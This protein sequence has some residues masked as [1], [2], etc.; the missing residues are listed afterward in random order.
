MIQV[1]SEIEQ[2]IKEYQIDRK[3]F[4]E[5]SKQSYSQIQEKIESTFVDKSKHWNAD[6]HWANMGNYNPKLKCVSVPL[7]KWDD[8][9]A[10]LPSIIPSPNDAVYVLFESNKDYQPKYW[11]YE[12]FIDEL[13]SILC[14]INGPD[15]F[16]IVSKKFNWLISIN[17]HDV[18]TYVGDE[19]KLNHTAL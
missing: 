11:L 16:Y 17:H 12:A 9:I 18:I 1:R 15:D 5:V 3:R 6:I 10:E 8:W 14:G 2:A 19:L 7:E 4:F 13:T